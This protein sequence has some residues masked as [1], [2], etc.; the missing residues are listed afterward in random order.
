MSK[1][2][3]LFYISGA[4]DPSITKPGENF[5]L[6]LEKDGIKLYASKIWGNSDFKV[7]KDFIKWEN[8][9]GVEAVHSVRE[10]TTLASLLGGSN[11]SVESKLAIR[12]KQNSGKET[13]LILAPML[14]GTKVIDKAK[15]AI[16]KRLKNN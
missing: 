13:D 6:K 10:S 4:Q 5:H 8:V 16:E 12:Y 11:K 14:T 15:N 2:K 3:R 7:K 1:F 9:I